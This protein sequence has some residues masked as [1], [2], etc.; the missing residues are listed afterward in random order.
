MEGLARLGTDP[1][2][3]DVALLLEKGLIRQLEE[4]VSHW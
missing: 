2:A 4:Q 1:A 3:V